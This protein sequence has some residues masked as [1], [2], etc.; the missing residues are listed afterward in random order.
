VTKVD[1]IALGF[2]ALTAFIGWKKGL[3]AS[4]LSLAGIV[5]GAWLG[6]RLAPQLLQ[7]GTHSPYTPLAALAGAAVGAILLETIGALAGSALRSR[8]RKRRLSTFD[9]TGGLVLGAFA[10]LAVVWVLGAVALLLPGQTDL[11]RGAQT[12]AL[13]QRLN[14][15]LAPTDVLHAL[16]TIDPFPTIAGPA[17]P[18]APPDPRLAHAVGVRRAS[19]SVVRVL[20]T[21]CG[22]GVEGT[23]WVARSDLI[24]TAAHV[25]A[26][27]ND[28][29]VELQSGARMPAEVVA[30]DRRNDVAVLRV[31]DLGLRALPLASPRPGAAVGVLGFPDNGPFTV[32]PARIGRTAVVLA[33][34]AYG[35]GPVT[36]A[37][38]SVRGRVRHGDSGAPAVDARGAVQVT[39]FAARL[40]A[41][42]GYGVPADVVRADLNTAQE[43]V[44]SGDCAP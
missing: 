43:P 5:F 26:G 32:T 40:G 44:S 7:D 35:T 18:V 6:S 31:R 20:G 33:E 21:A 36:R 37:I 28:T 27:Q 10:G 1:L 42:G 2:V 29:V 39:I 23:G 14:Q 30:F 34:D 41:V 16:A 8:V 9:A 17:A 22:V 15:V 3:I 19:P 13:L 12:S 24:V 11:R 25:V 4:A 38:T